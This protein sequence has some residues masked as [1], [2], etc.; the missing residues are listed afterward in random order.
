MFIF[1][2][3][4]AVI[5]ISLLYCIVACSEFSSHVENKEHNK[6][7]EIAGMSIEKVQEAVRYSGGSGIIM[8]GNETVYQWGDMTKLYDLK[9]TSKSIGIIALGLAIDDG[10]VEL[11][12]RVIDVFPEFGVPP[13]QNRATG[14]L[15]Q[16]KIFNLAT[17][18][19]GFEK[20]GGYGSLLYEPGTAWAYSD[21]GPNWLA[22]C[23][24]CLYGVD[25][26][27]LLFSRVFEPIGITSMDLQW[28]ENLYREKFLENV[29][30]REFGGIH[31]NVKA[32]ARIGQIFLQNGKWE[33]SEIIS[34]SFIDYL[35]KPIPSLTFLPV[36]N[37]KETRFAGAS[38][39]YGLLWWNNVDGEIPDF[40]EDA[41]WAWGLYDSIILVIPSLD[42]VVARAGDS[43]QT[44]RFP[45][46]SKFIRF[47]ARA[48]ITIRTDRSPSYYKV[49]EPFFRPIYEA[50][51]YDVPCHDS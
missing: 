33:D 45:I 7:V 37:D 4:S 23:L 43:F 11:Y 49:L 3:A 30:R 2:I 38:E 39:H 5:F 20:T 32:M 27:D 28:R 31:A 22:D 9:S 47:I 46:Y 29:P 8:R 19:A 13:E 34:E 50:I 18:T 21:G 25:L 42:I 35:R 41:F 40:P 26:K 14:W 48:G 16:I 24:T 17:Q 6:E 36:K 15:D 51:N 1:R 44:G 12:D 10:L